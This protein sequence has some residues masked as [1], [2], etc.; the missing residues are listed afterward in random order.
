[1]Q[2]VL[3]LNLNADAIM[4]LEIMQKRIEFYIWS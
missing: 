3:L 1:M 4:P 2:N